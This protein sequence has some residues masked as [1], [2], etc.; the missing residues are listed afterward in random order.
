[1]VWVKAIHIDIILRGMFILPC[2]I[3]IVSGQCICYFVGRSIDVFHGD[4]EP[5]QKL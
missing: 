1:M 5:L 2:V 4:V 3:F